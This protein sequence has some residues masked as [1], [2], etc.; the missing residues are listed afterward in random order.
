[1]P[2]PRVR[3]PALLTLWVCIG[4]VGAS[5]RAA[6]NAMCS[7]AKVSESWSKKPGTRVPKRP[8]ECVEVSPVNGCQS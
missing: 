5:P 8:D 6:A 2:L 4:P 1:V 7:S 3:P